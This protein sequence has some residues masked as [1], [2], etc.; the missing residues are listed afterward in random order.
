MLCVRFPFLIGIIGLIVHS[1][2][3]L[4]LDLLRFMT[5]TIAVVTDTANETNKQSS[6]LV[7]SFT[8]SIFGETIASIKWLAIP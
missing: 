5:D 2:L 8:A 4:L 1:L 3:K 7:E 6:G